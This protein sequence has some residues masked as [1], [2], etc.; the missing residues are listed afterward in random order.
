MTGQ[1]V[2]NLTHIVILDGIP[3]E[4]LPGMLAGTTMTKIQQIASGWTLQLGSL[5]PI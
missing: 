2:G 4:I 3:G 5:I 1:A